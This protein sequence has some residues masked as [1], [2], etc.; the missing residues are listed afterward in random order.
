M[1]SNEISEISRSF[2]ELVMT[3]PYSNRCTE[4]PNTP[5]S[6]ENGFYTKKKHRGY[7]GRP[8]NS[9]YSLR[10]IILKIIAVCKKNI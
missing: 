9:Q 8:R 7:G 4:C 2:D 6:I 10:Y 3:L 5:K 1:K